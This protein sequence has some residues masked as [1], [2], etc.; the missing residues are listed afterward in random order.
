[1]ILDNP[2]MYMGLGVTLIYGGLAAAL[3][4]EPPSKKKVKCAMQFTKCTVF[5]EMCSVNSVQCAVRRKMCRVISVHCASSKFTKKR[6][7][8]QY[9]CHA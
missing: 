8:V 5:G 1:M 3:C 9:A 7:T 4:I 6:Q 2:T